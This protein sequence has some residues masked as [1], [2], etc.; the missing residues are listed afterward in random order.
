MKK[1]TVKPMGGRVKS[2]RALKDDLKRSSGGGGVYFRIPADELLVRFLDEPDGWWTIFEHYDEGGK[3]YFGCSRE[4]CPGCADELRVSK[5]VIANV[6]N[7]NSNSVVPLLMPV[8]L[9]ED[10]TKKYDRHKTMID[11]DYFITKT[12]TGMDT[13]YEID[14]G[15]DK[16]RRLERFERDKHDLS[17]LA[18]QHVMAGQDY[19]DD[20]RSDDDDE[21]DYDDDYD[22]DEE[23]VDDEIEDAM[24]TRRKVR[25]VA[26][27]AP[28]RRIA[29]PA[30]KKDTTRKIRRR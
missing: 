7:V 2:I 5:R 10:A 25:K 12:G 15:P 21:D 3:K 18:V 19:G 6:L 23:G 11:R 14:S 1:A 20:G 29:K 30:A 8:T 24:P 4:D 26:K 28:V 17:A 13:K 22:D 9:A 16:P 27:A